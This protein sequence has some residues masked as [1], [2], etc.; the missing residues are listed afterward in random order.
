MNKRF[1]KGDVIFREGDN[2]DTFFEVVSGV[3]GIYT[4][5]QEQT[6]QKLTDINAGHIFGEMALIDAFPRSATA[7]ALEDTELKE[8]F[9]NDVREYFKD[10]PD[11]ITFIL[12]ELGDRLGRL[13]NEYADACATIK[14]LYPE[15]NNRKPSIADKI[16]KFVAQYEFLSKAKQPSSEE[17]RE[18]E[19][20]GHDNGFA[21]KV[22]K[23]KK[24]TVIFKEGDIGKCMYDIHSGA[25]GIYT[26]YGT[27]EEKNL[28]T[29]YSDK[30]FGEVGMLG[31]EPRTATAVVLEDNT[32][33]EIIYPADFEELFQKNPAKIEMV[34]RH[35]S[36]RIRRLTYEYVN[37]CKM[38]YDA[39]EA[40]LKNSV[41][42]ELKKKAQEYKENYYG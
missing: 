7:V 28:T 34:I 19:Q 14:E 35:L 21:K 42:E 22:E 30:F 8:V 11:K 29:L 17:I 36:F 31:N 32:T 33:I 37:A 4:N 26:G 3:V 20:E 15:D 39:A 9:V 38:I 16:K 5:Y 12:Q 41:N 24:G 1:G 6:E 25:V 23:Y 2:G 27:P 13:T 10:A 40:E 18:K